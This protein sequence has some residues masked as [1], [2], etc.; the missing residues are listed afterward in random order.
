MRPP[1]PAGP[2]ELK[3]L[4]QK[5]GDALILRVEPLLDE[6]RWLR[7]DP[8]SFTPGLLRDVDLGGGRHLTTAIVHGIDPRRDLNTNI[9]R[10]AAVVGEL[11]DYFDLPD[12][13]RV[14]LRT[15]AAQ[16][17]PNRP[18]RADG[19]SLEGL[20]AHEDGGAT[21]EYIQEENAVRLVALI[22]Y[23]ERVV[24]ALTI[25]RQRISRR[26][27]PPQIRDRVRVDTQ[28][29]TVTIDDGKPYQLTESQ[30]V[31]F[32][33]L[34][35]ANGASLTG[36]EIGKR[37]KWPGTFRAGRYRKQIKYSELRKLIS[38]PDRTPGR[39]FCLLL[40]PLAD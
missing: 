4:A 1:L 29:F 7:R 26:I 36:T 28:L 9:A 14:D 38:D 11:V 32:F 37:A 16:L 17:D 22:S 18:E 3:A 20:W 24:A 35:E 40:P 27:T 39:K 6:L 15:T 2:D 13:E 23:F 25:L 12:A 33:H 34:A 8:G 5:C 21:R 19:W 31:L 30:A 10:A